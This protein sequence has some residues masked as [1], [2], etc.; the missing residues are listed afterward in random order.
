MSTASVAHDAGG[1]PIIPGT[2][3]ATLLNILGDIVHPAVAPVPTAAFLAVMRGLGYSEPAARQAISRCA[4]AGWI[5]REKAG[6]STRWTLSASG[7]ALVEEGIADVERLADPHA[8]WDG[9][10][11]ILIVTITNEQRSTRDRVYRALRWD[12]FGNPLPSVWISPHPD[13]YRR[14]RVAL[15]D[16]SLD[17][18]AMSFVGEADGLGLPVD[19]LVARAWDLD[20]LGTAYDDLV[21]RYEALRPAKDSDYLT[22]LLRLD[23]ELQD[24]L[25]T[26]PHLPSSITP[27]WTGRGAAAS[28]LR[29]R[30]EWHPPAERHWRQLVTDVT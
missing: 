9:R 21:S 27:G 17:T 26:D 5:V 1:S 19:E 7:V 13:R 11:R 12:G 25:V 29:L 18:S 23:Q 8:D 15:A 24:L 16:L 10:W 6:R 20:G 28:L 14:V 2:A 30:Q 4:N 22:S 3:Q